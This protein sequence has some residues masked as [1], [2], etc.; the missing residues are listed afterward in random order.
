MPL[1]P[2]GT[3]QLRQSDQ[4]LH[5]IIDI[6]G[7][8]GAP[9]MGAIVVG[10]DTVITTAPYIDITDVN[11]LRAKLLYPTNIF[12][13]DEGFAVG[14]EGGVTRYFLGLSLLPGVEDL[15]QILAV[16]TSAG[17]SVVNE[18]S[19]VRTSVGKLEISFALDVLE[20]T[21]VEPAMIRGAT[22]AFLYANA[23]EN[24]WLTNLPAS[25]T[26]IIFS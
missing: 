7:A 6:G 18:F 4:Y 20:D 10:Q 25:A 26:P 13:L 19:L 15:Y 16:F 8:A 24:S 23:S 14:V 11:R 17:T 21:R 9:Q 3:W 12:T 5:R 2:D 1:L 22:F